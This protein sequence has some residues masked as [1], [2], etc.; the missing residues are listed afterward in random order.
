MSITRRKHIGIYVDAYRRV[1]DTVLAV[2]KWKS[3][4][5]ILLLLH[6]RIVIKSIRSPNMAI[7]IEKFS[8]SFRLI[9]YFNFINYQIYLHNIYKLVYIIKIIAYFIILYNSIIYNLIF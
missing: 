9:L 8:V 1:N 3:L 7:F 6:L 5:N 4:S 2:R